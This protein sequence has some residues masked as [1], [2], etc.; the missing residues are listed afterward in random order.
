M[1]L[2]KRNL[3]LIILAF[4]LTDYLVQKSCQ[5]N[6]RFRVAN[7]QQRLMSVSAS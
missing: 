3:I 7:Y 6:L 5:M 2:I 1:Y 4:N